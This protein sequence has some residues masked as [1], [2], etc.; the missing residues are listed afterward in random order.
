MQRSLY[1]KYGGFGTISKLVLAFYKRVLESTTLEPYFRQTDMQSLMDH[2]TQFFSMLLGG[3]LSYDTRVL[4]GVHQKLH[5]NDDA[6]EEVLELLE[7]VFEDFGFSRED[8]AD[9]LDHLAEYKSLIVYTGSS[10][11]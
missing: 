10:T 6:F 8:L 11:D 7:E 1:D 2:Q 9:T 3:P 5:I 4:S